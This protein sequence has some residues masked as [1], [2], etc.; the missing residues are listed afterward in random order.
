MNTNPVVHF[1]MPAKDRKRMSEFYTKTF[2]WKM[3]QLGED[4]GN[5]VLA[6]TAQTDEKGMVKQAGAING[7]FYQEMKEAPSPSV[8]IGVDDI[9]EKMKMIV[10]AGGKILGKVMDIPGTGLY[11]AFQDTEGNRVG[12]IQS[13]KP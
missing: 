2:G 5:Y 12:M 13:K 4:M 11:V 9:E 7:G 10:D 3:R 6:W 8:V 1:E